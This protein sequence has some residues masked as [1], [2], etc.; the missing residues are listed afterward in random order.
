MQIGNPDAHAPGFR[1][2]KKL[3]YYN[4]SKEKLYCRIA[5]FKQIPDSGKRI[6]GYQPVA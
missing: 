5:R 3:S 6:S 1:I 4:G 2:A